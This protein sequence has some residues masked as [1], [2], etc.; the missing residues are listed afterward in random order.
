MMMNIIVDENNRWK[1]LLEFQ[2]LHFQ[3]RL[4]KG[5]TFVKGTTVF[6]GVGT[7]TYLSSKHRKRMGCC[8]CASRTLQW[9]SNAARRGIL[10]SV[11][12]WESWNHGF[13]HGLS[14]G[15]S[16]EISGFPVN[17]P[18][19]VQHARFKS[20]REIFPIFMGIP[21]VTVNNRK[22]T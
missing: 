19:K 13:P 1:I 2:V 10:G 11:D 5:R 8:R 22:H 12:R 3:I 20:S 6:G 17:L 4:S 15:C 16:H 9:L 7:S 21:W 14:H 18:S